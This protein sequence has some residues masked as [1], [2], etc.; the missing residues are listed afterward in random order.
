MEIIKK[1]LSIVLII[2]GSILIVG[3]LLSALTSQD[4]DPMETAFLVGYYLGF[5]LILG[6]G[7]VLIII[8][9]RIRKK[10]RSKKIEKN[11]LDSLPGDKK[12]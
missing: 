6:L 1:I 11:L 8:G 9:V 10:I 7:V 4:T 12:N 2:L 3:G 5:I